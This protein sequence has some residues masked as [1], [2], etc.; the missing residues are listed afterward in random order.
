MNIN[1]NSTVTTE[2]GDNQQYRRGSI[3]KIKSAE[4]EN[5]EATTKED[6]N[7][8]TVTTE[9]GDSQHNSMRGSIAKVMS[10][11]AVNKEVTTEDRGEHSN[12]INTV[13][14]EH[15]EV[16]TEHRGEQSRTEQKYH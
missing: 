14:T 5:K 7:S 9:N 6:I 8:S 15:G 16:T 13:T 3:A 10:A 2:C 1:H 11:E 4:V 12:T